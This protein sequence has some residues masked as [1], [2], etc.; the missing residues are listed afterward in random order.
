MYTSFP[1]VSTFPF[2][3]G[4]EHRN[5]DDES[6]LDESDIVGDIMITEEVIRNLIS[7]ASDRN[8]L[9]NL[10]SI[11]KGSLVST[12]F[13]QGTVVTFRRH[14]RLYVVILPFVFSYLHPTALLGT[15]QSMEK[16]S[17]TC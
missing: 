9:R 15:L 10:Q 4:N 11:V 12:I 16:S 2:V 14:D 13:D 7:V 17:L 8:Y 5:E 6:T 3:S 1:L